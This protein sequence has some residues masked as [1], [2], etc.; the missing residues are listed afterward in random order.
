MEFII[1]ATAHFTALITPGPDFFLIMQTALRMRLKYA[2]AV[3]A[4]IATANGV[5]ISIAVLGLEYVRSMHH[6]MRTLHYA[7][8]MYLLYI[9]ILLL[10]APR[11]TGDIKKTANILRLQ[12]SKKQF[13]IGLTSG[14]LN[15]KNIIFY[16]SLFTAIVSPA[17]PLYR[18]SLYGLWM[19]AMV[20]GWDMMVALVINRQRKADLTGVWLFRMEKLA[21]LALGCFGI[22]LFLH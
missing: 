11:H 10:K 5:Y 7:G 8:G 4:G 1:L 15:P 12:N 14:I 22:A 19:A 13:L 20:L 3:C 17:T 16:L 6:L 2:W 9:G 21:G 18:R